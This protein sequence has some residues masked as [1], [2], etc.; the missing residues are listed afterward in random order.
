M[1]SKQQTVN[2]NQDKQK[3]NETNCRFRKQ[4]QRERID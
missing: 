1:I 3:N 2:V 4:G